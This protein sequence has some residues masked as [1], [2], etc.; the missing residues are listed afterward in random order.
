MNRYIAA[1]LAVASCATIAHAQTSPPATAASASRPIVGEPVLTLD[2]A[3]ELG[4]GASPALDEANAGV[5]VTDAARTV[6]G[7]RPNPTL[8]FE[9]ENIAG[10][11]P[12]RGFAGSD[13]TASLSLPIELG[14]KR[15]ARVA[16]ANAQGARARL[17]VAVAVADLWL[18]ITQAYIRAVTA[19]K[20]AIIAEEQLGFAQEGLRIARDRVQ[21][22]AT[23]PLDEQRAA[24]TEVNARTSLETAKRDALAARAALGLL[25]GQPV[26]QPLD[27]SWFDTLGQV[28]AYGPSVE[29]KVEGTLALAIATA[30]LDIADANV[31]LARSQRIPDLT[32]SAGVRRLQGTGDNA[33]V[34]GVSIPLPFF[35]NGSAQLSQARATRNQAEARRRIAILEA[36]TAISNVQAEVAN[37]AARA[38]AAGPA[39]AAAMEAARIARIGY[40]Q[41][42]FEQI[43]L[44]DAERALSETRAAAVDA[45]A[46]YHDALARLARLTAVAPTGD[47]K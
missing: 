13:T 47:T 42:K 36:R 9:S 18:S 2:R 37:A 14:G 38:R 39:I 27:I 24:V 20:R 29:P 17:N 8:S 31:G 46:A 30:D 25:I 22:G 35:N 45:F 12:Y 5:R 32:V 34:V 28:G 41:G 21:V 11:G 44:I 26:D 3:I 43:V 7:L 16:V 6:A 1:L 23:S 15:P 4:M 19:E 40:G 10:T 33:A